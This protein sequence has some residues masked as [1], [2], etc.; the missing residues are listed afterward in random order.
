M[1]RILNQSAFS[2]LELIIA[3]VLVSVVILGILSV[4]NVLSNNNQDYGQRYL[5]KS[6]TQTTLNHILN[7]ASLAIGSGTINNNQPDIGINDATVSGT[8]GPTSFCIHQDIPPTPTNGYTIDTMQPNNPPS[9]PP[10]S[11]NS[12]WLCYTFFPPAAVAPAPYSPGEII[13]CA[14]PYRSDL[15]SSAFGA[16]DCDTGP[17]ASGAGPLYL[18]SADQIS[19]SSNPSAPSFTSSGNQMLFSITITNCLDN[20]VATGTCNSGGAGV[21]GD[22][23]NNPE[24]QLSGSISPPQEGMQQTN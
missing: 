19:S 18:G 22:P 9:F 10:Y 1:K 4:N 14:M 5:V 23:V 21:S 2:L 24:V 6:N 20:S 11:T 16:A 7:N 8:Y 17:V 15:P 13:Y 12:R 3:S